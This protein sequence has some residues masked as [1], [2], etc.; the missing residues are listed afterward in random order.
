M[1]VGKMPIDLIV[2]GCL[3][4]LICEYTIS[5]KGIKVK[6]SKMQYDYEKDIGFRLFHCSEWLGGAA[7]LMDQ[8]EKSRARERE[9]NNCISKEK[10]GVNSYSM[11]QAGAETRKLTDISKFMYLWEGSFSPGNIN[12]KKWNCC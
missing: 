7:S 11:K 8:L 4:P 5:V 9:R 10:V 3:K 2:Q 6:Y 1:G 12:V